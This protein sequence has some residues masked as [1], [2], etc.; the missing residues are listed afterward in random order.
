MREFIVTLNHGEK[1][2]VRADRV[3]RLDHQY[4]ELVLDQ[5]P[6]MADPDASGATV[7]MFERSRVAMVVAREHLVAEE[8]CEPL[9]PPHLVPDAA[10]D[11]PF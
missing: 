8:K 9:D 3:V 5:E 7:A 10:S 4:L 6:T 2:T 11:I 1:I